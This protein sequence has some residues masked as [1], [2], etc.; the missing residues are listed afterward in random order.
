MLLQI[1]IRNFFDYGY[2]EIEVISRNLLIMS[3]GFGAVLATP[4][5]RHIKIDALTPLLS[6]RR[7]YLLS[8]PLVVFSALVCAAMSYYAVQFSIDEWEYAPINERWALPF[9]LMYP[10]GFALLSFHFLMLCL[11]PGKP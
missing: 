10:V 3:G 6:A 11:R 4:Q 2:P 9:T 7:I 5:M 8:F 1:F